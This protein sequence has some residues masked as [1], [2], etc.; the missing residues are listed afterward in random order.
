MF[1]QDVV[2][3]GGGPAGLCAG[4]SL[5]GAGY[6]TLLLEKEDFGGYLKKVERFHGLADYPDGVS[7]PEYAEQLIARAVDNGVKMEFGEVVEIETYSSCESVTCMDGKNYTAAAVI[8]AGGRC[9]RPLQVPGEAEFLNRGVIHCVLCD[10]ALYSGRAVAVCGGGDAGVSE[11]LLL[12]RHGARVTIIER[13]SAL[14]AMDALKQQALDNKQLQFIYHSTVTRI[15]G[16][17]VVQSVDI[18]DLKS[19][20]SASLNVDGVVIDVGFRPDSDY[21]QGVVKLDAE[22]RVVSSIAAKL[23]TQHAGLFAAGDI[24]SGTPLNLAGAISDAELA[25][26]GVRELLDS[27]RK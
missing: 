18:A 5:A 1:D 4:A 25:A 2:I 10:A 15:N 6:R 3:I 26:A 22:G 14:T 19:G 23:Q 9:A 24:R 17:G 12:A 8:I 13:E 7:G 11:A 21:L 16:T 20:A 27:G